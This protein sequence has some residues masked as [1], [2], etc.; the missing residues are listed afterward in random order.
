VFLWTACIT[1]FDG[2]GDN[3]DYESLE[4]LLK[5]QSKTESGIVLLG[6]TGEGLSLAES[7]KRKLVEFVCGLGLNTKIIVGVPGINLYQS[8]EWIDFCKGMPIHGYLMTTPVYTRPGIIGQTLWFE[9]LLEKADIPSMLYNVPSRAGI[10]LYSETVRNLSKHNKFWAIK[11]SSG[12]IDT[13]IEYKEAASH[14]ELF[15]GDDNMMPVMAAIGATGLVSVVSNLWPYATYEYVKKCLNGDKSL[16]NT[17]WYVCKALSTASNPI[18]VK[19]LLCDMGVIESDAVRL[20]LN[21]DDLPSIAVLRQANQ[22]ILDWEVKNHENHE[23][24]RESI[25]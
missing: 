2:T 18:P 21:R 11:D 1:P 14:I 10:K 6:S 20:P 9:K 19:V 23:T 15:C 12:A 4:R 5:I 8:M 7:E 24:L 3:I 17:W 22:M 13:M 25:T 16:Y